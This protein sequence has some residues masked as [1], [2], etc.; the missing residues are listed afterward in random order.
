MV[1]AESKTAGDSV[2]AS[3]SSDLRTENLIEGYHVIAEWI[4]FADAR[5]AVVLTVGGAVAGLVIPTL[6]GYLTEVA[7]VHPTPWWTAMVSTLFAVC[8]EVQAISSPVIVP[9]DEAN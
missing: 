1:S 7:V 6:R 3:S 2:A 9:L 4:R 8:S 5:A